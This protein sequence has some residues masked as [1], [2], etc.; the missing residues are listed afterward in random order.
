MDKIKLAM[1]NKVVDPKSWQKFEESN[2]V[3]K[4]RESEDLWYSQNQEL[5]MFRKCIYHLYDLISSI[6]PEVLYSEQ[7]QKFIKYYNAMQAIVENFDKEIKV[8]ENY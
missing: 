6:R 1:K 4:I 3:P 5:A 2:I 7:Y 8:K